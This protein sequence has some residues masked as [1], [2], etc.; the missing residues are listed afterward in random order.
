M[1]VVQVA[2]RMVTLELVPSEATL[3]KIRAKFSLAADD[4]DVNFGVVCLDPVKRLYS[5]LADEA[6]AERLEG[7]AGVRGA[8]S[9]PRIEPFGPPQR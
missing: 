9:N 5:V 3:T 7:R 1:G 2:S 4:L 8:Y 6:V